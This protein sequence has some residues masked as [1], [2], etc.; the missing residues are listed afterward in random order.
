MKPVA[1]EAGFTL[2]EVLVAVMIFALISAIAL[3]LLT[4]ALRSHDIHTEQMD[5]ISSI[6]RTDALLRGD[7]GQIVLRGFRGPQGRTDGRVFAGDLDGV[8][9]FEPARSGEQ[10][11]ILMLTRTGW[12]N[13]GALE[14]RST[15][16]R[17]A[18]LY[19]GTRLQRRAW[20]YPDSARASEPVTVTVLE[21]AEDLRLEFLI[22][23]VWRDRL[24]I[25]AGGD[26][27]P[28]A[29]RAVRISYRVP[30][31]GR[32]EHLLLTPNAQAA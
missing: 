5:V 8:N 18:W 10:R 1:R 26:G 17:V 14:P 16:Q 28:V 6:Q 27:A 15:L 30:G 12:P 13:P 25:S 19:D 11:E 4:T 21:T 20:A 23:R 32:I 2:T 29:P 24:L 9:P 7:M 31:R 3:T 22:G